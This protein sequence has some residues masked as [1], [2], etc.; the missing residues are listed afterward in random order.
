MD[1]CAGGELF[2]RITESGIFS[3]RHCAHVMRM[4]M[5]A[6]YYSIINSLLC[7]YYTVSFFLHSVI[8]TI[9]ICVFLFEILLGRSSKKTYNSCWSSYVIISKS[10][11]RKGFLPAQDQDRTP[12]LEAR[13]LPVCGEKSGDRK[14]LAQAHRLRLLFKK[15]LNLKY[16]YLTVGGNLNNKYEV[17]RTGLVCCI[18]V[19][20]RPDQ[21]SLARRECWDAGG[22]YV[23]HPGLVSTLYI[24]WIIKFLDFFPFWGNLFGL[25]WPHVT[26][27]RDLISP[28]GVFQE[29][30]RSG[31][32]KLGVPNYHLSIRLTGHTSYV[33]K[34][35][36]ITQWW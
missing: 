32:Q 10:K 21:S 7:V 1:F 20:R 24:T 9:P 2:D 16:Y 13:E 11:K 18:A 28:D 35:G 14:V 17:R 22:A 12:R 8:N 29:V 4:I 3:E 34:G 30:R 5:R 19:N 27:K 15:F 6:V 26:D 33:C 31:Y 25:W 36:T 23:P